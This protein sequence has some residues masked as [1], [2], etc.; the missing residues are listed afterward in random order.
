MW[1][2]ARRYTLADNFF[3]GAFGGSFLNHQ[4]LV[5]A[6]APRYPD[7]DRS[8]AK[9]LISAIETDARGRVRL[10]TTDESA[11]SALA[12]PPRFRRDGD[13]T[14]KDESGMFWAVS[15]TH[16]TLPTSDLV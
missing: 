8:P 5:C 1:Q 13:L 2:V 4:Y 3:M 16:L 7:A 9:D 10:V 14:P 11:S 12:G 15:Y 6:C